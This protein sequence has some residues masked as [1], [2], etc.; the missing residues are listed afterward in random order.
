MGPLARAKRRV[1]ELPDA[2]TV[3]R[4]TSI[5]KGRFELGRRLLYGR[6]REVR[7]RIGPLDRSSSKPASSGSRNRRLVDTVRF[8]ART[9]RCIP[10]RGAQAT[11]ALGCF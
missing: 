2:C 10:T 5:G 1:I 9:E 6:C 7:D 8:V 4:F 3:R 11:V